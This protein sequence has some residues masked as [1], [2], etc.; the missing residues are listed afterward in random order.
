L[1]MTSIYEWLPVVQ[2][3]S[4]ACNIPVISSNCKT[5][6]KEILLN[7]FNNIKNK[8]VNK[9]INWDCWILFQNWNIKQLIKVMILAYNNKNI[10]KSMKTNI[11]N[12][13][14]LFQIENIIKKWI[15][16]IEE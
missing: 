6:P 7:D 9:I 8:E 13:V 12:K 1:I 2:I 11:H 3:E 15:K 10:S 5:W 16:I 14:K 4:L